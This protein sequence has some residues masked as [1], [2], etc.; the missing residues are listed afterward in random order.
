M[1]T[2]LLAGIPL[3][4]AFDIIARGQKNST[5]Q[6]VITTIKYDVEKGSTV[7][8]ALSRHPKVFSQLFCALISAGEAS[9]AMEIMFNKAA[10]YQQNMA[11]L[12]RKIKLA[13]SYPLAVLTLAF[14]V[15][16]ALLIFVVPQFETLFQGFGAELPAITRCV[17]QLSAGFQQHS[18]LLV[19]ILLILIYGLLHAY[20]RLS[21]VAFF[22]D[23]VLLKLPFPGAIIKKIIIARFCRTLAIIFAAGLPL[24]EALKL[25]AEIT[26]NRLFY[27]ATINIRDGIANGLSLRQSLENTHMFPELAVQMVA[28]GEESGNLEHM[29]LK[30]AGFYEQETDHA[31]E[32]LNSLLEPL[33]MAVLGLLT[34]GLL[35]AMYLPMFKLGSVV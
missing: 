8:D 1:S 18:K 27:N 16:A 35:M 24:V 30:I 25:A 13:L 5:M 9:G 22:I 2:L 21:A 29:L 26:G 10:D 31:I 7:H 6:T 20:K 23:S 34:G 28:V 12:K 19:I 17:I 33:I 14:L 11:S 3:I 15:T 4:K 32:T